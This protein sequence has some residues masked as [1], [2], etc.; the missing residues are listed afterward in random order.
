MFEL[1]MT[2]DD[3]STPQ[4]DADPITNG[5]MN[6]RPFAGDGEEARCQCP[7]CSGAA[8]S[9]DA[10]S[11]GDGG[12]PP[13]YLNADDRAAATVNGKA[14]FSIDRAG[15]Q[16]TGFN[17]D[18]MAP[19]PGWGGIAGAAFTVTYGFRATAPIR[20]P[21]DTDGFQRFNTAQILQA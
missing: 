17:P 21:T 6:A 20:M 19:A 11:D 16:L 3:L 2:P 15:L 14:S 5:F 18:T 4:L 1:M 8:D 13:G 12:A 9:Q 7:L 10:G